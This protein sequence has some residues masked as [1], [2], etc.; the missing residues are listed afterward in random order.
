MAKLVELVTSAKHKIF[1]QIAYS[2]W[3]SIEYGPITNEKKRK[4]K[5]ILQIFY[6]WHL[7]RLELEIV[8]E[9]NYRK[10]VRW[11]SR[12]SWLRNEDNVLDQKVKKFLGRPGIKTKRTQV[13][14]QDWT[15]KQ[16]HKQQNSIPS[17]ELKLLLLCCVSCFKALEISSTSTLKPLTSLSV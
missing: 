8:C 14:K 17:S 5:K 13:N 3:C 11:C 12:I 16:N 4:R 6:T 10:G 9:Q 7:L 2:S 1:H 15:N